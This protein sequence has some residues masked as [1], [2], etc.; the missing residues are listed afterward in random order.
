M[1]T[2]GFIFCHGWGYDATFWSP[3]LPYFKKER[4]IVLDLGYFGDEKKALL[5][6]SSVEWIGI[7]HSL[8]LMKL[9]ALPI[10]FHQLIGLHGFLHFLGANEALNEKRRRE[11]IGLKHA[12]KRNPMTTLANFHQRAGVRCQ[13]FHDK[14]L[15]VT[16]LYEDLIELASPLS[17]VSS[18]SMLILGSQDDMIVPPELLDD[19]FH[20]HASVRV[21]LIRQAQ[22]GLGH[23]HPAWVYEKTVNFLHG[24]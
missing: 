21:E 5:D 7:G 11:W 20:H 24:N 12:F 17:L 4:T 14:P 9:M 10:S 2:R 16:R 3:L 6:D 22:H 18:T 8:G 15:D 1:S 23:L 13:T 19:N